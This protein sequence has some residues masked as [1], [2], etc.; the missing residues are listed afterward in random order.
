MTLSAREKMLAGIVGAVAFV[1][2]NLLIVNAFVR[3][4][5]T[6]RADMPRAAAEGRCEETHNDDR[7][8]SHRAACGSPLSY[9]RACTLAQ[10]RPCSQ[11]RRPSPR[12][13]ARGHVEDRFARASVCS[14][15]KR[16]AES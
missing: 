2:L 8:C 14:P 7:R 16:A 9:G 13:V 1:L 12:V 4:H 6:L 10:E 3:K 5:A 11:A 15:S